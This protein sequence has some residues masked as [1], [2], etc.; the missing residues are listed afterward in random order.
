MSKRIRNLDEIKELPTR[1]EVK[2]HLSQLDS[3]EPIP[4]HYRVI[5]GFDKNNDDLYPPSGGCDCDVGSR[6][7]K[8]K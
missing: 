6:P 1:A 4:R 7:K 5:L 3:S 2:Y 8:R